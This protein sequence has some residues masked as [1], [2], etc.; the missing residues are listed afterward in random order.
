MTWAAMFLAAALLLGGR[1]GDRLRP[2][3]RPRRPS[4]PDAGDPLAVASTLDVFAACLTAGMTVSGAASAAAASAPRT[5]ADALARAANLL[6]LGADP[7]RAWADDETAD[8]HVAALV[9]LARR[10]AASGTALAQG[11]GDLAEQSRLD[12]ADAARAACERAGVL[13]AA[14]L[15]LCFLP[16]FLCLGI[17]PV[18]IGLAGEVLGGGSW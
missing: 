1:R 5:M 8:R 17:V 7:A 3:T 14:P 13:I 10:S 12:A 16:A 9:R 18:V 4:R 11:V 2:A 15:G 6:A